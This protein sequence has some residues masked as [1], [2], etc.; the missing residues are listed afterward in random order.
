MVIKIIIRANWGPAS[1]GYQNIRISK[2]N[3]LLKITELLKEHPTCHFVQNL[4]SIFAAEQFLTE[5]EERVHWYDQRIQQ[6]Q[7]QHPDCAG[8]LF[9]H[10]RQGVEKHEELRQQV[11]S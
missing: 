8:L 10:P 4:F 11:D 1:P 7:Q 9:H 3:V 6:S 2:Y 5:P